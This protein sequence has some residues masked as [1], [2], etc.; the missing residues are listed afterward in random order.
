MFSQS[1]QHMGQA[2]CYAYMYMKNPDKHTAEE[3]EIE[4]SG[5]TIQLT[6][7]QLETG[8]IQ[9]IQREFSFE[10][11]EEF[12]RGLLDKYG[13]WMDY[14]R[15]WKRLRDSSMKETGFPFP[16]YR[17][18]QR[19]LAVA[20]YR[21][22]ERERKLY[23]QASTGIGK[24]LA[25]IFPSVKAMAEGKCDKLFYLTA[26]T[27][28][29]TVAEDALRLMGSKGLRFKS[30]TLRAKEKICFL[31]EAICNPEHCP[32]AKGHYD[33]I[34]DALLDLLENNDLITPEI[35]AEY[36]KKHRVCPH[37][38]GLDAALWTDLVI[39]DYNH[40][41]DPNVYLK[42]FFSDGVGSGDY[43][44]LIDEAH[45]LADRVRDM[46]TCR[47][48]K[49][50]F[51][52]I[53][54]KLKDK[55]KVA[56]KLRRTLDGINRYFI[57]LRKEL[58]AQ[59]KTSRV[60]A[61]R[62]MVF[63]MLIMGF[64]ND[65]GQWL[66]QEKLNAHELHGEVLELYFDAM[67]FALIGELYDEHYC[68]IKETCRGDVSVSYFC[69][70]PSGII[71]R[72]LERAKAAVMFSA[73]LTPLPYFREMLG[74]SE[75]DGMIALPSPFRRERMM[76]IAHRGISTKYIDRERSVAPISRAIYEAVTKKKGNYLV[77]FPSYEYMSRVYA[78]FS[79]AFPEINTLLQ[80]STMDEEERA[81]FLAAFDEDN[82]ETLVGFCVLGGIFSEG[83][84]L[85]G[86]RLIG[87]IIVGV[88]LPKLS[89]RQELIR[90]Y[91]DQKNGM[92]FDYAYVYPG[93]NKVLQ[94]AGRVI[95]TEEDYGL[96]LLIDSRFGTKKYRSLFPEHW[97]HIK[98]IKDISELKSLLEDFAYFK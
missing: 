61:D 46:Y 15:D 63:N 8:E 68:S 80:Q 62:D 38:M 53:K 55:N 81:G 78:L 56:G 72:C 52:N 41:F 39:G 98:T 87:S 21:T 93:M 22:I 7:C 70:D 64:L 71:A 24:T 26:K 34:N 94:A 4:R 79:Q 57:D 82:P 85:K 88:G 77:F 50:A 36:A 13:A 49:S 65:A 42:R 97:S 20:V 35:T 90:E 23:A 76:L 16:T 37:E 33:R 69:L 28:T 73:T 75:E 91:F 40:A 84:D 83:I 32:Y 18:G 11:L 6:Y 29:R 1:E 10:E 25:T 12:F 95:R 19:K 2:K 3:K 60:E 51:Y 96:V 31:D 58:E 47:L 5:M 92:G 59:E 44:F 74:G 48:E 27:V 14:E 45:N 54:K 66:T 17:K 9:R 43:I 30:V 89:M 67:N 86:D